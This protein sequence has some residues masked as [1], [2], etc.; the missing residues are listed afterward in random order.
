MKERIAWVDIVKAICIFF[1]LYSHTAFSKEW[2]RQDYFFLVGFLFCSGYTFNLNN[3]LKN[4][5]VRIMDSLVIPYLIFGFIMF[6][7]DYNH[8]MSLRAN[9]GEAILNRLSAIALGQVEWFIPCLISVEMIYA[10]ATKLKI[11]TFVT[12]GGA[13]LYLLGY[14]SGLS[15]PWHIDTAAYFILFF[16]LGY[17]TQP[18]KLEPG[19][20]SYSIIIPLLLIFIYGSNVAFKLFPF[21]ASI[22]HFTNETITML[23]NILG[24]V[25]IILISGKIRMNKYLSYLGKNSLVLFYIHLP[26][27]YYIHKGL[28]AFVNLN[29]PYLNNSVVAIIYVFCITLL[30]YPLVQLINKLPVLSG[31]GKAFEKVCKLGSK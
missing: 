28:G 5:L 3:G 2:F 14:V 31:K 15:L 6:F 23:I 24:V 4:R 19:R 12:M 17:M 13:I 22:N 26:F 16:H 21:N 30:L 7:F 10:I 1:V 8:I 25:V 27:V 18:Y 20:W 29:S 9:P 11:A